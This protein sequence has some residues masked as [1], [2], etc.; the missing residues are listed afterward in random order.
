MK[1][2]H[3]I[4]G[5]LVARLG[6]AFLGVFEER[7]AILE[8]DAGYDRGLAECLALLDIV[9]CHPEALTGVTWLQANEQ[10]GTACFVTTDA[11]ST[12][13]QLRTRGATSVHA[14]DPRSG[15]QGVRAKR[16][17]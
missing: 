10:A 15:L 12:R 9:H 3:P 2:M 17:G 11:H 4:V 14:G 6:E 8:F 5:Q 7:A 13:K 1:P 16:H